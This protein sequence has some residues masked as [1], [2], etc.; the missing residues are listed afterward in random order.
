MRAISATLAELELT[1][2]SIQYATR[3]LDM[4]ETGNSALRFYLTRSVS[5]SLAALHRHEEAVQEVDK[6]IDALPL[7]WKDDKELVEY[8][9]WIYEEKAGYILILERPD[10]AIQA[11]H[12]FKSVRPE[13]TL[14]GYF[15]DDMVRVWSEA[16]DPDGS[17]LLDLLQNGW[18]EKDRLSWFGYIFDFNDAY[19]NGRFNQIAAQNGEDGRRFLLQCYNHYMATVPPKSDRIIFAQVALAN[20]YRTVIRDQQKAKELYLA[21]LGRNIKDV[22]LRGSIDETLFEVRRSLAEIIFEEFRASTNPAQ[23][24]KLLDEMKS[25]PEHSTDLHDSFQPERSSISIL[26]ALMTRRMGQATEFEAIMQKT[27]DTCVEGLNDTV[28]WNDSN[29]FRLLSKVLA[30]VEGLERD[31]L[32]ALSC[33][34]SKVTE[35]PETAD[36]TE[37]VKEDLLPAGDAAGDAAGDQNSAVN[38][39]DKSEEKVVELEKEDDHVDAPIHMTETT[40]SSTTIQDGV[41]TDSSKIIIEEASVEAAPDP[42]TVHT[43]GTTTG[44][45]TEATKIALD[46]E[47]LPLI[48]DEDLGGGG[49]LWC[50]G[51]CGRAWNRWEVPIYLCLLCTNC[52]LCESCHGKR[53]AQSKGERTTYWRP[54]CSEN[55]RYIKG[56][57]KGWRGIKDGVI[58]IEAEDGDV[59]E[60][61]VQDWLKELKEKRWVE[62]W[63]SFWTRL[64][65]VKDLGF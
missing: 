62:A 28:G 37:G 36:E 39:E 23:K 9:E 63:E 6:A 57:I 60:I 13:K 55:H 22:D 49:G 18:N 19:A 4:L 54:Y 50:D 64:E 29:S 17:K 33:Q 32:I 46:E 26:V 8:V 65:G 52:D 20:T 27:F 10:E 41:L 61:K 16:R 24:E 35:E 12:S 11:Y 1:E 44:T 21:V 5:M 2:D 42:T 58:R 43:A 25:F 38:G 7:N 45:V 3:G 47:S 14:D 51:E 48:P 53:L 56:P 30:C 40:I 59:E 31:A 15:L 34:F